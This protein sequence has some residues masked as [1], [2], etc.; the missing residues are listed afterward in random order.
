[1]LINQVE[2]HRIEEVII[3]RTEKHRKVA[4]LID[5]RPTPY[6]QLVLILYLM[7]YRQHEMKQLLKTSK[8]A[9]NAVIVRAKRDAR[10]IQ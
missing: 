1:M 10:R 2:I 5:S 8:Q 3:S 7:G 9:I 4:R 6:A